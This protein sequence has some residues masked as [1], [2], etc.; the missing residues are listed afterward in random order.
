ML[1]FDLILILIC[2]V[3]I[4]ID[5]DTDNWLS[6]SQTT[7]IK[8]IFIIIVFLS[9]VRGYIFNS[10]VF[11]YKHTW[12]MNCLGQRM[13]VMFLLYSGYGVMEA[14][15]IKGD[16]YIKAIPYKRILNT[17]IKFDL[18]VL[19]YIVVDVIINSGKSSYSLLQ[20]ILSF[21]G[22][23]SVGNSNWYIFAI[24]FAY[25]ATW[26]VFACCKK[27]PNIVKLSLV[28]AFCLFYI[29]VLHMVNKGT[30]WY[31]TILTYPL[32]MFISLYKKQIKKAL[33]NKYIY[34]ITLL[35]ATLGAFV[36]S[37]LLIINLVQ[38]ILFGVAIIVITMYISCTNFALDWCGR[39]LFGIYI[40][41]RI[42]MIILKKLGLADYNVYIYTIASFFFSLLLAYIFEI[43]TK[44]IILDVSVAKK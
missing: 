31:D 44:K 35:I 10:N 29:I 6:M 43:L 37:K 21:I 15:K 7:S 27:L 36:N 28:T 34:L 25:L 39:N 2:M 9:H 16:S 3:S 41:Q 38:M 42:P 11:D 22:W 1:L 24:I 18:A 5:K 12:L 40:L 23:E 19:L 32:G 20:I 30:W 8:G 26:I 14:I 4:K 33:G 13:V 17:L